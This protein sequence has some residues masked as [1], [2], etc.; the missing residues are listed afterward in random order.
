MCSAKRIGTSHQNKPEH[1]SAATLS[2]RKFDMPGNFGGQFFLAKAFDKVA[3][4]GPSLINPRL[5]A[6][7][8]QKLVTKVNTSSGTFRQQHELL[9][10]RNFCHR[11][12]GYGLG[13]TAGRSGQA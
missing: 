1:T 5:F 10:R 11:G 2:C 6:L 3:V 13:V 12:A 9:R 8:I 7:G 4:V